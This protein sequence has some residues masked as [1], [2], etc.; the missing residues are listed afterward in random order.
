MVADS[1]FLWKLSLVYYGVFLTVGIF[2]ALS[3]SPGTKETVVV[4]GFGAQSVVVGGDAVGGRNNKFLHAA[5]SSSK[6][7]ISCGKLSSSEHIHLKNN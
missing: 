3:A 6:L 5:C 7:L 1:L 2:L 4:L